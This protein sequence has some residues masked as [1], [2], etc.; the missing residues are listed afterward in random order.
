MTF[1]PNA[2]RGATAG[3]SN[4]AGQVNYRLARNSIVR[5]FHKGRLSRLDV[6]DAHPELLRAARNIGEATAE[7]CPI[8]ADTTVVLVSYLFGPGL[9]AS[10]R[11]VTSLREITK[12]NR[13]GGDLACHVVEV[14]P[15]CSWNHLAHTFHL[16]GRQRA[17]A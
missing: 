9:P 6:C 13:A 10:G 15:D 8:C 17:K 14:C 1:R 12:A 4:G 2:L 5:E 3:A 7:Q 11:C 16:P